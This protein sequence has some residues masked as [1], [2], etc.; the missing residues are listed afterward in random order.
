MAIILKLNIDLKAHHIMRSIAHPGTPDTKRIY[1]QPVRTRPL[2]TFLTSG[3]TLLNAVI[4]I[5]EANGVKSGA[6]RLNGGGFTSFS[7]VMPALSKSPDHA[8]YFSETFFV[9]GRIALETASVT[10]G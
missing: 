2:D 8:V 1:A 5:A 6:F 7:Y 10:F 3:Q 4:Q 9:E